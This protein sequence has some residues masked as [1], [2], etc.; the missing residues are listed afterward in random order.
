MTKVMKARYRQTNLVE[1][2]ILFHN[3]SY[4]EAYGEDAKTIA[5]IIG[6]EAEI[7]DSVLTVRI[8]E[9]EQ[10]A[11]AN[12]L[13]DKEYPVCISEMRDSTGNYITNISQDEEKE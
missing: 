6:L 2:L 3:G 4:F 9:S 11:A 5:E 13:I 12:K 7:I 1:P 10:K 8:K